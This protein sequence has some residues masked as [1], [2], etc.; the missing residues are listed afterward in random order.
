MKNNSPTFIREI[1]KYVKFGHA[2]TFPQQEVKSGHA[3]KFP[4]KDVKFGP[5]N[6]EVL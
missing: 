2:L 3:L 5:N 1:L 4:Y 6:L